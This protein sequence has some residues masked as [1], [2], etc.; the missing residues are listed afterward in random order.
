MTGMIDIR[1]RGIGVNFNGG[2]NADVVV[3]APG[4][5]FVDLVINES[6]KIRLERDDDG[7]HK[8]VVTELM[9][10][11]FY[12]FQTSVG[13][14]PDP[15]SLSQP[16][17]VHAASMA[18]DPSVYPW[19]D[20]DWKNSP[21]DTY[22][23]YELHTG[24]FTP[25]GTFR[26]IEDKLDHLLTLG[27]TA[28]ELM[29]VAQ[30]PGTRNWGYDGVFPFAV[31]NVYGGAEALQHLV[32][33]C[34]RKKIAVILD[35]VYNHLGPEGNYL[36]TYGPYF[37]DKYKT[38]WGKAINFDD[39]GCDGV[40][41]FFIENALMWL[42]DFHIDALR[43]DAVHAIKDFSPVHILR[44][45]KQY[46][47]KLM[48]ET[49]RSYYLIVES[50]L[51][52]TRFITPLEQQGYGMD[53]QWTDEF[54]HALR[55]TA[56][57]E[58]QGYY[59]DF[60]GVEHLA[61]SVK[62]AYVYT[63]QYSSHREKSFGVPTENYPG[64]GFVVFSQNHDQTG[65]RMLGERTSTLLSFEKQKLLAGMVLMSP[66]LPLLFMGEE[67]SEPHPFLYF[68]DPM[69]QQ[70][71]E[72]IRKGRK[73][74]FKAFHSNGEAPDPVLEDTFLQSKLQWNLLN[75][76]PYQTMFRYYAQLISLRKKM[77]V[78]RQCD[79]KQM[80]VSCDAMQNILRIYR[81]S[82][83]QYIVAT[84]NFSQQPYETKMPENCKQWKNIL[85]SA[86]PEWRGPVASPAVVPMGGK[87]IV[88]PQ[89]ILMY[90]NCY[91]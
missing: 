49:G 82:D 39:A 19:N 12:R 4:E 28:I 51:N 52:D 81:W 55:V 83:G 9:P 18:I 23:M 40:R 77:P 29:P 79:R 72:A 75:S 35:V 2:P 46:V 33:C 47:N 54:H 65:N 86:D 17:G 74:E 80:E 24:T 42:R 76:E 38:P 64:P 10:G 31:Q 8:S 3:W 60:N 68:A 85:D 37:T 26:E 1:K 78:L 57:E 89:S 44:E 5:Q 70:L 36:D 87:V 61:K 25:G 15:A 90:T 41:R 43:F 91:V 73:E 48:E 30:F 53:A 67:W 56:G 59:T 27:I 58:K 69:D 22:I 71:A 7:Y 34:H 45:I 20:G 14:Y 11:D 13:F 62:D 50:D 66:Y 16:K 21:L 6:K 88:Q 63:G 84:M 32:D